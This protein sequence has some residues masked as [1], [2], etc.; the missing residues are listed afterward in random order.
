MSFIKKITLQKTSIEVSTNEEAQTV[1]DMLPVNV[2]LAIIEKTRV[3]YDELVS[4]NFFAPYN[5]P[6]SFLNFVPSVSN[7]IW[8]TKLFYEEPL[9]IFY[10]NFFNMC[11]YGHMEASYLESVSVGEYN[12]FLNCLKQALN[13]EKSEADQNAD[14]ESEEVDGSEEEY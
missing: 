4:L 12:F 2:G 3:M 6:T 10:K 11:Y 5:L 9:D 7:L 13:P 8:Y 1:F 14:E